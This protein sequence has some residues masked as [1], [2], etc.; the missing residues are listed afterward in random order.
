MCIRDR[1]N[2]SYVRECGLKN[3][4]ITVYTS[5]GQIKEKYNKSKNLLIS[6]LKDTIREIKKH[7]ID[8]IISAEDGTRACLL[9]TSRCV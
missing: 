4:V 8:F 9:Y 2:I 5:E 3:I 7:N 1:S 6:R